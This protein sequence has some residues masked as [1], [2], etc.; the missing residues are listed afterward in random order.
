MLKGRVPLFN[1]GASLE[2]D[3]LFNV[4]AD[5]TSPNFILVVKGLNVLSVSD[6]LEE[7]AITHCDDI[8]RVM[9]GC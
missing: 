8:K 6:V 9:F 3:G 4:D 5:S 1:N 2:F 7:K